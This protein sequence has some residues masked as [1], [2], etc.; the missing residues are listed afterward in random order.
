LFVILWYRC[1]RE[2]DHLIEDDT[3]RWPT[4]YLNSSTVKESE[5]VV[6]E[7]YQRVKRV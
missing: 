5:F 1:K 3:S 2:V 7:S 6:E 4:E